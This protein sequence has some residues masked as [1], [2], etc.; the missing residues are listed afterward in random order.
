[1]REGEAQIENTPQISYSVTCID[2]FNLSL[3]YQSE[4]HL[5]QS[6]QDQSTTQPL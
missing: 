5:Q 6:I 1:M 2:V 4:P 3:E